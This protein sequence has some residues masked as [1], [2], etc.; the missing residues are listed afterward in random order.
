[1]NSTIDEILEGVEVYVY[2]MAQILGI[3]E[4]VAFDVSIAYVDHCCGIASAAATTAMYKLVLNE[5][6]IQ[7][8]EDK[9]RDF[10]ENDF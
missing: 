5:M 1:M 6:L 9:I 3:S 2:K 7:L 4:G 8:D 10:I